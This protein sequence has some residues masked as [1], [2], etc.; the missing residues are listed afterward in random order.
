MSDVIFARIGG[1][2]YPLEE[3]A[4]PLEVDL[5]RLVGDHPELLAGVQM[6]PS[7]PRRFALISREVPVPDR[8]DGGGRWSLDHLFVDQDAIPTLVEVKRASNSQLRREV[9]GQLLDYA[10]NAVRYWGVDDLA[11]SF[12]STHGDEAAAVLAALTSDDVEEVA[13]WRRVAAN[14]SDGRVRL[15]FLADRIPTELQAI[16]EFLNERI[17]PTEVLAVELRQY[18]TPNGPQVLVPRVLG[19]TAAAKSTKRT[20]L[21]Y[22]E[23]LAEASPATREVEDR[24]IEWTSRRGLDHDRTPKGRKF[25]AEGGVHL[26]YL[27]PGWDSLEFSLQTIREGDPAMADQLM[28]DLAS[29]SSRA[30]AEK[31]PSL[32]T[33]DIVERFDEFEDRVLDPYMAARLQH[34]RRGK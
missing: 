6:D 33:S 12:V 19:M 14:L 15:I 7:S 22:E 13:F 20:S 34:T 18:R 32:V 23:L 26:F 2:L 5:Q 1:D 24:L 28:A 9:V 29:F 17:D 30:P 27:Y 21:P 8:V 11:S 25:F 31:N 4:F 16:V 3:T 10:A